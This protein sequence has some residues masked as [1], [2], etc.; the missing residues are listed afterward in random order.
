[1]YN[2]G[3]TENVKADDASLGAPAMVYHMSL[4]EKVHYADK[5]GTRFG[6]S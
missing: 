5:K 1:M 6:K 2:E 3:L 4:L